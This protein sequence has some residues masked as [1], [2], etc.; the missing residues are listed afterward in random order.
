MLK[1]NPNRQIK[2]RDGLSPSMWACHLD[3][4]EHFK[5]ISRIDASAKNFTLHIAQL[6]QETDN[7]GR[8]CVHWS[9]RK[10]EPLECLNVN[11]PRNL[12]IHFTHTYIY[13][14]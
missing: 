12:Y 6:E 13:K 10:N 7:D 11:E 8:T 5:L 14:T 3:R 1:Y 9:V 4:L 2:D